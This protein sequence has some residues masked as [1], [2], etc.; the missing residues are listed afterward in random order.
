MQYIGVKYVLSKQNL[1]DKVYK[2]ICSL[3]NDVK[4]YEYINTL[5]I[6]ILYNNEVANIPENLKAFDAQNYLYK[7]LFNKQ[8]DI[9]DKID[10]SENL[11][12]V[13]KKQL[14]LYTKNSL[15]NKI[16]INGKEITLPTTINENNTIYPQSHCNGILDLGTYEDEVVQIKL[17]IIKNADDIQLG[18]LDINKYNN[19]FKVKNEDLNIEVKANKLKVTG[20]S[21]YDTNIFLPII[22]DNGWQVVNST[23]TQIKKVYN[24]F[25]GLNIKQGQNNIELEFKPYTYNICVKITLITILLMIFMYYLRKIF[26][27]RNINFVVNIFWILGIIIYIV[28]LFKV[29]LLSIFQTFIS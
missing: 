1:S 27:I 17:D 16:L 3:N 7:S 5:P 13:G 12:I 25:I 28:C 18:L 22:Y 21:S 20:Y 6:G 8:D 11:Q 9:I 15:I 23:D 2:Y 29:Y 4:L 24:C 26:D 10:F 14:Y 19:I